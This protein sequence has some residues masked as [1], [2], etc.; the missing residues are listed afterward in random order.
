MLVVQLLKSII[1]MKNGMYFNT[2][3]PLVT[4]IIVDEIC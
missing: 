3:S 1:C 4:H 2:I